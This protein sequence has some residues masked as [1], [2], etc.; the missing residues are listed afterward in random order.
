VLDTV[1]HIAET[2]RVPSAPTGV[3]ISASADWNSE[4]VPTG[5]VVVAWEAVMTGEDAAPIDVVEY[6]VWGPDGFLAASAETTLTLSGVFEVEEE[7]EVRV[8]ARSAAGVWSEFSEA[9]TDVIPAP[10]DTLAAPTTPTV[11]EEVGAITLE[12]DGE[13]LD[14][15]PSRRMSHVAAGMA[16]TPAGPFL[17]VGQTLLGAG[18]I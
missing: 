5:V 13:L 6:E 4:G 18:T 7:V 1:G 14:G 9:E 15:P 10:T 3:S 17:P 16:A 2:E 12:W 11:R 8:R